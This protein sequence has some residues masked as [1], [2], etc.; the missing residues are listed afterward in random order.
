MS[1]SGL[2]VVNEGGIDAYLAAAD[3]TTAELL[4]SNSPLV[5]ALREYDSYFRAGLWREVPPSGLSLVLYIN[6]YQLFLAAARMALSGHC[7]AV[8]PL[9]RTALESAAYGGLMT[10]KPELEEVWMHRHRG[11]AERTTCRNEF[12][13]EKAIRFLKERAPDI[14]A[15][16][17]LGYE[18]AIDYGAHPNIKGV[19][20]HVTLDDQR[21]DGRT[22][23]SHTSLYSATH[24]ET[25]R[26]LCACLDFGLAIIGIIALSFSE[27]SDDLLAD[28]N[29]LNE[30]KNAA[31]KR[32]SSESEAGDSL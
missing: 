7:A 3:E 12:T 15:L 1:D 4:A 19:F 28:L 26:G 31:T 11:L 23:I 27:V 14:H 10:H 6:A 29:R 16:A 30:V 25:I 17:K 2:R 5:A 9:L 13:F 20:G 21:D 22:E 18:K 24:I 32:Y 8:F